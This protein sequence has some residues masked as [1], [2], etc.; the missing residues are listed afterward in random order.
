ML[1]LVILLMQVMQVKVHL[2]KL[3][4]IAQLH[5]EVGSYQPDDTDRA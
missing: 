4:G 2:R 1:L 3:S 5:W